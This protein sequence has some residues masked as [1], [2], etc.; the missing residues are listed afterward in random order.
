MAVYGHRIAGN[1]LFLLIDQYDKRNE[2]LGPDDIEEV[3][4]WLSLHRRAWAAVATRDPEAV[5]E[6]LDES[7]RLGFVHLELEPLSGTE[8]IAFLERNTK[9][10]ATSDALIRRVSAALR[11]PFDIPIDR[12]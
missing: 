10:N 7:R 8:V 12:T 2:A 5:G 9:Q 4:E 3:V 6:L 11:H 1:D